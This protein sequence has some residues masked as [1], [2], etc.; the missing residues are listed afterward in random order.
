LLPAHQ[1]RAE[2]SWALLSARQEQTSLQIRLLAALGSVALLVGTLGVANMMLA[3]VT[4]R[5]SEIGLRMTVGASRADIVPQFLMES[6]LMC[7]SGAVVGLMIGTLVAELALD[8]LGVQTLVH[9]H[10][11]AATTAL[12]LTCGLLAGDYPALRAASVNP[13]ESLLG[14]ST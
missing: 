10:A 11:M 7:A 2:G 1:V 5:R 9:G 13:S 12:A 8:F 3:A 14:S 4:Q 6:T